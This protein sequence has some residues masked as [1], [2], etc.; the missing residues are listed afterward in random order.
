LNVRFVL[1]GDVL[2][3]GDGNTVNLRL[4]DATTGAQVWSERNNL[5]ES[6]VTAESSMAIRNLSAR[7][8]NVLIGAE[9]KRVKTQLISDLSAPELVLR[10]FAL[11]GEDP[12][13]AGLSGARKLVDE[14]LRLEPDLVPALIL[15]AALINNEEYVD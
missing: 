10:A 6:D 11:G 3:G 1:E 14:A 9:E 7:L 4:V 8:R 5:Q 13:L 2:R 12:S 15:R